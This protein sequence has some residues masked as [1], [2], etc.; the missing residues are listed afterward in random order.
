ML[1]KRGIASMHLPHSLSS[2]QYHPRRFSFQGARTTGRWRVKINVIMV[3]GAASDFSNI[4]EAAWQTAVS[5]LRELP[6]TNLDTNVAFLV[7]HVGTAGVWLLIDRW[8]DGD[9]LRHHHFRASLDDPTHFMD[10]SSDHYG[11][12]VWELAVQA[13]ERQAWLDNVLASPTVPDI[14]AYLATG[15]SGS[16]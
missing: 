13:Y 9:L 6:E 12:C 3:K 4:V 8:E 2:Y 7:V 14:D 5:V 11:P 15:L 10:V 1:L 16:I